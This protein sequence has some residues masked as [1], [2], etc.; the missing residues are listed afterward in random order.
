MK[1]KCTLAKVLFLSL[2][3][4]SGAVHAGE[5]ITEKQRGQNQK[6]RESISNEKMTEAVELFYGAV[7]KFAEDE[8]ASQIISISSLA[9][10]LDSSVSILNQHIAKS[11]AAG[12]QFMTV[13][14]GINTQLDGKNRGLDKAVSNAEDKLSKA[15]A[16]IKQNS[17]CPGSKRSY[18]YIECRKIYIEA[19]KTER[20]AAVELKSA[21][22]KRDQ[23]GAKEEYNESIKKQDSMDDSKAEIKAG[24]APREKALE[25][26]E[27]LYTAQEKLNAHIRDSSKAA[28]EVATQAKKV[29]LSLLGISRNDDFEMSQGVSTNKSNSGK[30]DKGTEMDLLKRVANSNSAHKFINLFALSGGASEYF[31]CENIS[32]TECVSYHLMVAA[33]AIYLAMQ[34]RETSDY[35]A[36]TKDI[37]ITDD[38]PENKYDDQYKLLQRAAKVREEA[39]R[40]ANMRM[41]SQQIL[42]QM[43]MKVNDIA[44]L[45]NLSKTT[46]VEAAKAQLKKAKKN[47]K[48]IEVSLAQS[49]A[50]YLLEK[51]WTEVA[52]AISYTGFA[53]CNPF[54]IGCCTTGSV[55]AAN[56]TFWKA[57]Q[58][59][60]YAMYTYYGVK[61]TLAIIELVKAKKELELAEKHT[62][63]RC[64]KDN[65]EDSQVYSAP[66]MNNALYI[67]RLF[68]ERLIPYV[69]AGTNSSAIGVLDE[70]GVFKYYE[71]RKMAET[72]LMIEKYIEPANRA[73]YMEEVALKI[74]NDGL[75]GTEDIVGTL[76]QQLGQYNAVVNNM[77]VSA[78]VNQMGQVSGVEA[79]TKQESVETVALSG[80]RINPGTSNFGNLSDYRA[81]QK[82]GSV[83][84]TESLKNGDTAAAAVEDAVSGNRN[85]ASLVKKVNQQ[86]RRAKGLLDKAKLTRKSSESR[87]WEDHNKAIMKKFSRNNPKYEKFTS[88]VVAELAKSA[89]VAKK[90][91]KVA[92]VKNKQEAPAED[93]KKAFDPTAGMNF[94]F[95]DDDSANAQAN[96]NQMYGDSQCTVEQYKADPSSCAGDTDKIA[97]RE[98]L[99]HLK[100]QLHRYNTNNKGDESGV[101]DGDDSLFGIISKRYI[102]TAL[103]TFFTVKKRKK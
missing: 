22:S 38:D 15:R 65:G 13:D 12:A 48:K 43:L 11:E 93:K 74:V 5:E 76:T 75:D 101:Y 28:I 61:Y 60:S 88:S 89:V 36:N 1:I 35:N 7:A 79:Q 16:E 90:K 23:Y 47:K 71:I 83:N 24:E 10:A 39:L 92:V 99:G 41:Q 94:S 59:L 64:W 6:S 51:A 62:H 63:M 68:T 82:T 102:K 91:A 17:D 49:F 81:K 46:R 26:G 86:S 29:A 97:G 55:F 98:A 100:G 37:F 96:L 56:S 32:D 25:N 103:P 4:V 67:A 21:Q 30:L 42:Q 73:E 57:K 84:S 87:L 85:V 2:L 52:A 19:K 8:V 66:F 70:S 31:M 3:L 45:E 95:D 69:H 20:I 33:N 58:V 72:D 53:C 80:G 9:D 78:K 50:L 18:T 27:K 44:Q 14:K 77:D 34:I 40:T 54:S